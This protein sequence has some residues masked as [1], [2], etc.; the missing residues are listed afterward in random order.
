MKK[1]ILTTF[2]LIAALWVNAQSVN[3]Q[4][5]L[6]IVVPDSDKTTSS[7]YYTGKTEVRSSFETYIIVNSQSNSKYGYLFLSNKKN[8]C[9]GP[10]RINPIDKKTGTKLYFDDLPALRPDIPALDAIVKEVFPHCY[11]SNDSDDILLMITMA[12]DP[13]TH[14]VLEVEIGFEDIN[15][16]KQILAIPPYKIRQLEKL[17]I[18]KVTAQFTLDYCDYPDWVKNASYL[19]SG[20]YMKRIANLNL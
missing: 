6:D 2:S 8:R 11:F 19:Y 14:K 12:V 16:N 7:D 20:T 15:K 17:V 5:G 4:R 13:A 1:I 18:E 3:P 9:F 10:N